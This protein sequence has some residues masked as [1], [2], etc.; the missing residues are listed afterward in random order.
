[1]NMVLRVLKIVEKAWKVLRIR[2]N[3]NYAIGEKIDCC[4]LHL[5]PYF[6]K[7]F[8]K[9]NSCQVLLSSQRNCGFEWFTISRNFMKLIPK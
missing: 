4:E 1:M 9:V 5:S 2:H 6:K 3:Y 7:F 8:K